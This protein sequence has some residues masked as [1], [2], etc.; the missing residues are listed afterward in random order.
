MLSRHTVYL[1]ILKPDWPQHL[2]PYLTKIFTWELT[3]FKSLSTYKLLGWLTSS[4]LRYSCFKNSA[5]WKVESIFDSDQLQI[6]KS[7]FT[8]LHSISAC[9]KIMLIDII[10]LETQLICESCNLTG[11]KHFITCK[12]K[13]LQTIF[14]ISL[15]Y[16]CKLQIILIHQLLLET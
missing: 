2:R 10:A 3:S 4:L 15:I 11:W 1:W 5:I 8:F 6:F 13:N 7:L 14:Y 12:T 9:K 16:I